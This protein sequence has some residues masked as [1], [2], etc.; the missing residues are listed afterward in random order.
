MF[1]AAALAVLVTMALTLYRALMG[2]TGFDRLLAANAFGTK[3]VVLIAVI[4]FLIGRPDM[5]DL[6]L[7]YA[8]VNAV[9]TMAVLKFFRYGDLGASSPDQLRKGD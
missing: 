6:A 2:P 1:S 8:L 3:T 9:G 4:A 5:L 7:I